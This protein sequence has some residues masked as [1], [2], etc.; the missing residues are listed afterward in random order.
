M[1][2][3]F[4]YLI[5]SMRPEHWLKNSFIFPGLIFSGNLAQSNAVIRVVSGFFIFSLVASSVYIFNDIHDLEHDRAHPQKKRRPLAA[6]LLSVSTAYW[7]AASLAA[8]GLLGAMKLGG[9]FAGILTLY[10][11]I[12]IAYTMGVKKLVILDVMSIAS[13]F[14][15]RV[16]A[17]TDLARVPASDWLLICTIT[18]SLFL[19]FSKRR[20][21]ITLSATA[22]QSFRPV[23]AEYSI[24]FLDQMIAVATACTVMSYAL[25]TVSPQTVSRFGTR[26]LVF[27]IPFVLYGVYRYLYLIHQRD[28]G[29]DVA[30]EVI[31]DIPLLINGGLWFLSVILIIY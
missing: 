12:N 17:G 30:R 10:I 13:G 23:L 3:K 15:L 19:G 5:I 7:S 9:G 26:N 6:G 16:I 27:T 22:A 8:V 25:Y 14:V 24:S 29:G 31:Q 2:A 21:E 18:V 1:I 4:K 28:I 20:H 11:L